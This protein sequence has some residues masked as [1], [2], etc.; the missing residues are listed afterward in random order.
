MYNLIIDSFSSWRGHVTVCHLLLQW[1]TIEKQRKYILKYSTEFDLSSIRSMQNMNESSPRLFHE[2]KMYLS[3]QFGIKLFSIHTFSGANLK[4]KKNKHHK[5]VKLCLSFTKSKYF[6]EF[7]N[8][9]RRRNNANV[10]PRFF[11]FFP[12]TFFYLDS[13]NECFTFYKWVN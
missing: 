4:K 2:Y 3:I 12:V 8:D 1:I 10:V 6:C 7:D 11:F 13:Q 9:K 5:G